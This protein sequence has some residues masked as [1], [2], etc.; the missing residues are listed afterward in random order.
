MPTPWI[1]LDVLEPR[2]LLSAVFKSV[3]DDGDVYTVRLRGPGDMAVIREDSDPDNLGSIRTIELHMTD[4]TSRLSV[5]VKKAAEGD[6]YVNIGSIR[7][8]EFEGEDLTLPQVQAVTADLLARLQGLLATLKG[9]KE[10]PAPEEDQVEAVRDRLE[11][12]FK[13]WRLIEIRPAN[14]AS[15]GQR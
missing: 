15:G 10:L 2:V 14:T 13:Y 3:D 4:A 7:T 1:G 5:K 11:H 6:G 8:V 9:P 12:V